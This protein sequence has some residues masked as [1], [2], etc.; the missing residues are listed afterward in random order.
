MTV[1]RILRSSAAA[2]IPSTSLRILGASAVGSIAAHLRILRAT[3]SADVVPVV[4]PPSDRILGPGE[5]VSLTAAL[6][7]GTADTWTW[8]QLDGPTLAITGTGATRTIT[9]PLS[10]WGNELTT[11]HVSIVATQG[12]RTSEPAVVSVTCIPQ[13]IFLIEPGGAL[14]GAVTAPA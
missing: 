12:A 6:V 13:T 8:T 11:A 9:G 2:S 4:V 3:T 14:R 5:A 7:S 10:L 1:L